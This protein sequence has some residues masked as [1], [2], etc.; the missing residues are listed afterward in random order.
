M[1]PAAQGCPR[2]WRGTG[3]C[4]HSNAAGGHRAGLPA[5]ELLSELLWGWLAPE[6][7]AGSRRCATLSPRGAATQCNW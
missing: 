2:P 4:A 7:R 6:S 3:G 1:C 5:A